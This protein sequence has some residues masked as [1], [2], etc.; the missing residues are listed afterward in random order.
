M[1]KQTAFMAV[2]SAAALMTAAAPMM[3]NNEGLMT[4]YAAEKGWVEED[5]SFVFYDADG[6]KET[7][8]WKKRNGDWY[9]LDDDGRPAV[10]QRVDEF[11]VNQDGLMVK[12]Q[13]IA[14]DSGEEYDSPDSPATGSW[15]YFGKDGKI[16]ASKWMTIEGKTYYFDDDGMMMTGILE[17]DGETYYLGNE[18]D[19]VRK[20]GWILLEEMTNDTD[21]EDI[22]C[23]FD[24]NGKLIVNQMD[25]KIGGD[26]Y[27]FIDGKMQTGWVNVADAGFITPKAA[28]ATASE[29]DSADAK[30]S[31]AD[32]R[33]YDA[34]NGGRRASGWFTIEGAP[35]LSEEGDTYTFYFRSGE[36]LHAEKGLELFTINS[37]KY[38]FNEKGEMQTGIQTLTNEKGESFKYYFDENGIMKTGKQTIYNEELEEN[39]IWFFHTK[40]TNKGQGYHG[41]RDNQVYVS[42]LLQK[43]DPELRYEAVSIGDKRYLVNTSGAIQKAS[44]SSTSSSRP[45][46]GKGFK[47]IK[48]SNDTTWTV[49]SSG[50]I[51]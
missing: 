20:T 46:L 48:D 12:N 10:N 50:I 39:Q 47:D 22:W 43:A 14:A 25:R 27:T 23:Y 6:Y 9:Y 42:G 19:G 35:G 49:D 3:N 37:E 38:C 26:Y 17:L 7:N 16:I 36:A 44:A 28:A 2:L 40:G 4:A 34:E 15:N 31:L 18:H 29:A 45:E 24:D 21:D 33:Y 32:F 51:Q 11:Y 13:W 30:T 1:H 5:G 41:V 8:T